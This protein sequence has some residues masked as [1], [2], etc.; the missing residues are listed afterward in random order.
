LPIPRLSDSI[1]SK[2]QGTAF[3]D[4]TRHPFHWA[5][6]DPDSGSAASSG[7][8]LIQNELHGSASRAAYSLL[9]MLAQ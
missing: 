1:G 7:E 9:H 4:A 3:G 2:P 6:H 5:A 8:A